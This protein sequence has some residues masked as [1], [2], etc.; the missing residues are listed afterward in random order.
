MRGDKFYL[1]KREII[2]NAK[3][4]TIEAGPFDTSEEAH[5]VEDNY[6]ETETVW[7]MVCDEGVVRANNWLKCER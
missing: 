4:T 7:Y 1:V 5:K 6:P 2:D 3:M